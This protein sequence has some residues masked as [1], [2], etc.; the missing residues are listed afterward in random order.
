M[1]TE[2]TRGTRKP[3]TIYDIAREAGVSHQ[4]VS[5]YIRGYAGIMPATRE[6]V[7]QAIQTL[8]YRPN[9]TA[10][11]LTTGRSHRIGA[12]THELGQVGP[13][14][15]VQGASDAAREAGYLLDIV[16]LDA[17]DPA[18]IQSA[19]TLLMQHDLAGILALVST[20]EM[21]RAFDRT[22]FVVPAVV[23]GESDESVAA[24]RSQLTAVGVPA[25]LTHLAE[26]GHRQVIH[27]AGPDAWSAARNR[28]R[29]FE[30]AAETLG[31]TIVRTVQGDWSASSGYEAI[32]GLDPA[33]IPTALV[34]ANDQMALGAMLALSEH[35]LRVPEDVSVT[36]IDDIPEAAYLNPPLTTLRL[37]FH[38][39]GA[40]AVT[41][42][43][44]TIEGRETR[45]P[46][47][48]VSELVLRRSTAPSKTRN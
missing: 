11:S 17:S 41:R 38:A 5:R 28:S 39:D 43:V 14:H 19:L 24:T 15:I 18:A 36:G 26:L 27:I 7:A 30:A 31:V 25:L 21:R 34:A 3:A 12:L 20:D 46:H 44:D 2:S 13:S 22:Q 4:T 6:K 23:A 1:T 40:E 8:D 33:T 37:D 45:A 29:A 32:I 10:R 35:G 48:L 9:L 42:L 16:A 47:G